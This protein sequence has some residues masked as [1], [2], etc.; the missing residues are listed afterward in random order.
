MFGIITG[1]TQRSSQ[2]TGFRAFGQNVETSNPGWQP[3]EN[4]RENNPLT[5]NNNPPFS[6]YHQQICLII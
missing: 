6:L 2:N 4:L 5:G 1:A 3:F